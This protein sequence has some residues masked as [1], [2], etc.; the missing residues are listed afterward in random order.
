MQMRRSVFDVIVLVLA[1]S[2]FRAED[3]ATVDIFEI[4]KGELIMPFGLLAFLVIYPE[5][6]SPVFG[7]PV[8]SNKFIFLLRRGSVSAPRIPVVEYEFALADKSL[9][10]FV[11]SSIKLHCHAFFLLFRGDRLPREVPLEPVARQQPHLV[12][13]ARLFQEVRRAGNDHELLF[14]MQLRERRPVQCDDLDIVAADDQQRRRTDPREGG[15]GQIGTATTRDDGADRFATLSR[16]HQRRAGASA[17]AE[18]SDTELPRLRRLGEPIG[19]AD[20]PL[21]EQLDVEAQL[22]RLQIDHLFLRGQEVDQQGRE[23]CVVEQLRHLA[24]ARAEAAAATAVSEQNNAADALGQ[25]QIAV[26]TDRTSRDPD[27]MLFAFPPHRSLHGQ[28]AKGKVSGSSPVSHSAVYSSGSTA[29]V[30]SKCST[31]SNWSESRAWK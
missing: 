28:T 22:C 20:E 12:E 26:E 10:I 29:R 3:A 2:T 30:S 19:D 18:I 16:C 4:P 27:R 8:L 25:A 31:A 7:E 1:G 23:L 5:V 11:C 24:V 21:G 6:P 14:T 17:G 15:S 13:R 9:G